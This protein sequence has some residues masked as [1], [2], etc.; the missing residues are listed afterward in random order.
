MADLDLQT[1]L[2]MFND[3]TKQLM[4]TRAL[5]GANDQVN[6]IKAS[7]ASDQEKRA[8]LQGISNNL[9]MHMASLGTPATTMQ[10][11]QGAVGPKQF[12][13]SNDM[14]R[15]SVLTG[16]SDLGGEAKTLQAFENDPKYDLARI[17]AQARFNPIAQEK[18]DEQKAQFNTKQFAKFGQD[19]DVTAASSRN[20]FGLGG[21]TLQ[22]AGRI[23]ALM[24]DPNQWNNLNGQDATLIA[25]GLSNLVKGGVATEQEIKSLVP[26]TSGTMESSVKQFLTNKP[27]GAQLQAFAA[28]YN[29][30]LNREST[31]NK[32]QIQDTVLKRASANMKLADRDEDQ[33]KATVAQS[34]SA[35]GQPTKPE[36][37]I[38]DK[39]RGVTTVQMKKMQDDTDALSDLVKTAY[40]ELN[41]KDAAM[42]QQIFVKLGLNP[43]T[44]PATALKLIQS[45]V[46]RGEI[47]L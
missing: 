26:K 11:V 17:K 39:K 23:Q 20:A 31:E 35:Y 22:R 3:S 47:S 18:V 12:G 21:L 28:K 40:K 2:S 10:L 24:G 30:I 16:N 33:F 5:S 19:L 7:E 46:R 14:M 29:D 9:V 4:L 13:N 37:I 34:L 25:E 42:A 8:Q 38:I 1:A 41:G 43:S 6:Q 45:R 15:E 36:D 27:Q 32:F 44:P